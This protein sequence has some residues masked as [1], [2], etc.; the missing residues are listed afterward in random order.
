MKFKLSLV[1]ALVLS[2][3]LAKA[4]EK[5]SL[6]T[7]S[8]EVYKQVAG[9][10]SFEVNFDPGRIFGSNPGSQFSLLNG[11]IKYRSFYSDN[12]AYRIGLNFSFGS[13]TMIIQ[14]KD[15]ALDRLELKDRYTGFSLMLKPGL[16]KHFTGTKRLS[17][18]IGVQ[19]LIGFSTTFNEFENQHSNKVYVH[20]WKNNPGTFNVGAGVFAGIDYYFVKKLY[21]G[22]EIGYGL[23]YRKSLKIKYTDEYDKS[24]NFERKNGHSFRA[25]PSLATGNLRFGWTF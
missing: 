17:P 13:T 18:Y 10:R 15:T 9:D 2:F 16:E 7:S 6:Q 3:S 14:Q 12:L 4:Q 5:T 11:G 25:S 23:E 22:I 21:L 19:G 8:S 24:N 1:L 20:K